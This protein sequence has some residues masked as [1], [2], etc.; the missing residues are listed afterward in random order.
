LVRA[1]VERLGHFAQLRAARVD[2][3]AA[4][5]IGD[6]QLVVG[7]LRQ[8]AALDLQRRAAQ[9]LGLV[10]IGHALELHEKLAALRHHAQELDL[11]PAQKNSLELEQRLGRRAHPHQPAQPVS[12]R[13]GAD[14]QL[15]L[16]THGHGVCCA[17]ST[18]SSVTRRRS[19]LDAAESTVRMARAVRP[20]LPITLPR[21]PSATCSSSTVVPSSSNSSTSTAS[22]S[23]TSDCAMKRISSFIVGELLRESYALAAEA[24]AFST[25]SSSSETVSDGVAPTDSQCLT[26]SM[27]KRISTGS[28]LGS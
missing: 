27:S 8:I 6:V 3:A 19:L 2:H 16:L 17:Y 9:R 12:P 10:A 24:C 28:R 18:I 13:D 14:L 5:Q 22:G 20:C 23:S 21:S 1:G 26:R 4:D 11:A 7:R 25:T 15:R